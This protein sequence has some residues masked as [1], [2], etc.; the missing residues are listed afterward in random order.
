VLRHARNSN[1]SAP[2]PWPVIRLVSV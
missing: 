2:D 1:T